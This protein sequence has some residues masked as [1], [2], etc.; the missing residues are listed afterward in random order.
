[1]LARNGHKE[2]CKTMAKRLQE[3]NKTISV[4]TKP[5]MTPPKRRK[6][7]KTQGDNL[8]LSEMQKKKQAILAKRN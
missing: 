6:P 2:V 3:E 4:K 8:E 7:H 5:K 1:M